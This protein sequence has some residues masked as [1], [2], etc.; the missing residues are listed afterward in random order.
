MSISLYFRRFRFYRFSGVCLI[1]SAVALGGCDD[2]GG[3]DLKQVFTQKPEGE[4]SGLASNAAQEFVEEDVEAPDVFAANEPGLWDGRPSLGGVWVAHPDVKDPERVM[5]KN[6]SNG[7]FVIGALFR[8]ERDNPGP[9]LQ[10]SSD[11]ATA[12]DILAG[13]PVDLEV[14]ALR[15]EK[16][17]V[18]PSEPETTEVADSTLEGAGEIEQSTLDPIAAAGA[19]IEAAPPTPV[20]TASAATPVVESTLPV[21]RLEKPYIQVGIFNQSRNAE[22]VAGQMRASGMVP[23][24]FAQESNGKSFWRVVVGPATTIDER[25]ALQ[26]K[27]RAE[28]YSDA[29]PVSN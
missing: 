16:I 20:E 28:G 22:A 3:F 23:T 25:R 7:K 2:A 6:A 18:A 4:V 27:I 29:Y 17:A 24:V 12:L 5:I 19:A 14:V 21:S 9:R 11:A 10:L 1:L 15:R 13:A 8:R 26:D